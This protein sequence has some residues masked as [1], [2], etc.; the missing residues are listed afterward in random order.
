M[1]LF[2]SNYGNSLTLDEFE[3]QQ[4][5]MTSTVMKYLK[6]QW[7]EQIVQS[8]TKWLGDVGK[9]WFNLDEKNPHVYDVMKLKR[10]VQLKVLF[11]Q[12]ST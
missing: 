10:L 11:M 7:L 6:E 12:V 2:V 3:A 8:M 4:D 9:G 1:N 5:H